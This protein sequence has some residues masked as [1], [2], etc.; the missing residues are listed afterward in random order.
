VARHGFVL[1]VEGKRVRV[2]CSADRSCPLQAALSAEELSAKLLL[3]SSGQSQPIAGV[4]DVKQGECISILE[5]ERRRLVDATTA[6]RLF[7]A[8]VQKPF[9]INTL[10][11]LHHYAFFLT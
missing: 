6:Q 7:E 8:Q 10:P 5:A 1:S 3:L 11:A 9:E 2:P 4:I